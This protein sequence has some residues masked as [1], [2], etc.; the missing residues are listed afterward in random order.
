MGQGGE[1]VRSTWV[2]PMQQRSAERLILRFNNQETSV[3]LC[4]SASTM[5]SGHSGAAG[6]VTVRKGA[7]ARAWT[8]AEVTNLGP[9]G[10][11]RALLMPTIDENPDVRLKGNRT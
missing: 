6:C 4:G 2:R 10:L 3:G 9:Q 7:G 11:L 5:H 1:T 8:P